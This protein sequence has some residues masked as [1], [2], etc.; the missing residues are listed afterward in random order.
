MRILITNS[1]FA[2]RGGTEAY[3]Q[4]LAA[5]LGRSG[6][7]V[8]AYSP[9]LGEVAVDLLASGVAVI[10]D[11]AAAPWVPDILHCH[12]NTEAMTALLHFSQ[13]PAVFV[14]HGW[15]GWLD[16]PVRHPRVFQYVAVD[17][18]TRDALIQRHRIAAG[19]VRLIPNF[20]DLA[21]FTAR[22]SLPAMPRRGLVL[23]KAKP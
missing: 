6:H 11:L 9:I 23:P 12:H 19:R 20:I 16:T 15:A 21:R 3:T 14:S 22:G 1:T 4:D 7:E 10:D 18:P 13:S 8:V 5:A 2:L 17:G